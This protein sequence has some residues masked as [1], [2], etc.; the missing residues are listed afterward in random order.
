VRDRDERLARLFLGDPATASEQASRIAAES[1]R[2]NLGEI[3]RTVNVPTLALLFLTDPLRDGFVFGDA[4][5]DDGLQV[6][7]YREVRRPTYIATTGG[8]DLPVSGRFWMDAAT[9]R[10]ERTELRTEDEALEARITV[11]YRDDPD[12]QL[13]VPVRMEERYLR[14]S[15]RLE[16]RGVATYARFRR[17]AIS[18][19]EDITTDEAVQ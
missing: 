3:D 11:T 10:V 16:T 9:G 14:K 15:D 7:A 18:T 4:G 19:R 8:R 2:Y 1:A 5:R 12:A 17:F 13:W 6:V